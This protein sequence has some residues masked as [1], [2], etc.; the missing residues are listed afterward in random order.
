MAETTNAS[1]VTASDL[2][3]CPSP[4]R[5]A[6]LFGVGSGLHEVGSD[7]AAHGPEVKITSRELQG[8]K[9]AQFQVFSV[10]FA[11][12]FLRLAKRFT[13]ISSSLCSCRAALSLSASS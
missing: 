7:F 1:P 2:I 9:S 4:E 10:D 12:G 5:A 6:Q 8:I 3:T 11:T 13:A